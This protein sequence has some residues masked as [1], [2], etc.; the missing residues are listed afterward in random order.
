MAKSISLMMELLK[1][2]PSC[3]KVH[4][5]YKQARDSK[6]LLKEA[7]KEKIQPL[8]AIVHEILGDAAFDINVS[9]SKLI[10]VSAF[11][12]GNIKFD[13]DA[14]TKNILK[15]VED[16]GIKSSLGTLQKILDDMPDIQE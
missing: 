7:D 12:L 6:L 5:P 3:R 11:G 9:S 4:L 1:R 10:R 16:S 14:G 2:K 13:I 8:M 15:V